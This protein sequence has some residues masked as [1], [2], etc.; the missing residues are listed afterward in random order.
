[1]TA[2]TILF[3]TP[4]PLDV[5]GRSHSPPF[6]LSPQLTTRF[7]AFSRD[8]PTD[9][10][11]P[12]QKVRLST[13]LS[14]WY[15]P[16]EGGTFFPDTN[17]MSRNV[18]RIR[19]H[20]G[21]DDFH[22][23]HSLIWLS[24]YRVGG[25]DRVCVPTS[26]FCIPPLGGCPPNFSPS[27]TPPSASPPNPSPPPPFLPQLSPIPPSFCGGPPPSLLSLYPSLIP[28]PLSLHSSNPVTSLSHLPPPFSLLLLPIPTAIPPFTPPHASLPPPAPP[29]PPT[30]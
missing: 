19:R 12:P 17:I 18:P 21:Q 22:C 14:F 3:I 23:Q 11:S 29:G 4:A 8:D 24:N 27:F 10:S 9:A 7:S 1:M 20:N 25:E 16:S 5:P 6:R 28:P 13:L 15:W 26:L 30:L 2:A